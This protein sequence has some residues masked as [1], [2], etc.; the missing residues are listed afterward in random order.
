MARVLLAG[1]SWSTTSIHTKGFDSFITSAYAEGGTEFI[2][3]LRAA[4]HEVTFQPNHVAADHFPWSA[5]E[6][7][8]FDVVVLSDIGANTLLLPNDVF[9]RGQV[10][11]NR[12]QVL[13]DWVREGGSLLM[14]GGYLSFQGIEAKANYRATPIAEILPIEMEIGDDREETPQGAAPRVIAEHPITEGLG[15][16]WPVV[17][18]YHRL[19]TRT[20]ATELVA[21]DGLPF[22]VVGEA[23]AGRTAVFASDMGPHWLPDEFRVW[24][25]FA[26]I[27]D[28][29]VRW[30]A[31][32]S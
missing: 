27:W 8:A 29:L 13:A 11:P 21:V 7:S 22:V 25:G 19:R 10:R 31:R 14:V 6:L 18:G 26:T 5:E 12:L 15:E 32:E 30:L 28:R 17:L 1:E 23:G 4:G 9:A 3:A 20:E 2:A 16:E 24:D